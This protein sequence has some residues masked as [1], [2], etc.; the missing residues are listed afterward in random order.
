MVQID[1]VDR[2]DARLQKR[3]V[4]VLDRR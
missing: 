3:D 4:V 1:D 2:L